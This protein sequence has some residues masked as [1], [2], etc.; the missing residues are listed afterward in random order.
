MS[1]VLNMSRFAKWSVGVYLIIGL[2]A[3]NL[4]GC[5]SQQAPATNTASQSMAM[6]RSTSARANVATPERLSYAALDRLRQHVVYNG[7]YVPIAYPN[8]DVPANMGVCTDTVIRSYRKLGIDLQ[9]LVHEDMARNFYAYPNLPKWGL[10]APDTNIDH[11][12]V[13]NLKAFFTR[14][15]ARLPVSGNAS[16]YRPGDLVTWNLGGDQEH[17]GIVVDRLSSADPS[18]HLIVHNIG[19]GEK[20]EDVLFQMPIS[21]HYRYFPGLSSNMQYAAA[22]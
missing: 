22:N 3:A 20:M 5:S 19:E 18:R 14:H 2:G 1:S 12:R 11:R 16:D 15:G 10:N 7:V 6:Q 17:I 8:G 21:G 9:R 13:H 4:T